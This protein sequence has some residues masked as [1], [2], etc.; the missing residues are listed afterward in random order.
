MT[1]AEYIND[2]QIVVLVPTMILVMGL[3]ALYHGHRMKREAR[4]RRDKALKI[5]LEIQSPTW[6]RRNL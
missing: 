1:H 2:L 6:L 3:L 5:H 4:K